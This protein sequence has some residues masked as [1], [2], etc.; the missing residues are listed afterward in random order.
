M[1]LTSTNYFFSTES[2]LD[3]SKIDNV[4]FDE[5]FATK[6]HKLEFIIFTNRS[7]V[8]NSGFFLEF[9]S[10]PVLAIGFDGTEKVMKNYALFLQQVE[11]KN[12]LPIFISVSFNIR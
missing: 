6:L 4:V 2:V 5:F 10:F 9:V 1:K 11:K 8:K 12:C 7:F 3:I